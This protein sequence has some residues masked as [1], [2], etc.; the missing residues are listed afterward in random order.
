[1][2]FK[3]GHS[4]SKG[5]PAGARGKRTYEALAILEKNNFDP[6]Q[7]LI[8]CCKEAKKTYDNY[9]T[10]YD[11]ICEAKEASGNPFPVED[12]ADRYLKIAVDAAKEIASYA[13]PKLKSIEH[14]KDNPLKDMTPEQRLEAMKHAVNLLE[15]QI[16]ARDGSGTP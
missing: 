14:Q 11:A 2:G 15:G 12:K 4:L 13:Y 16:K 9:A 3:P 1:M 7:T 5:R 6:I 8:D 10:I